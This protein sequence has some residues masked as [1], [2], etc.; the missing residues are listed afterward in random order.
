MFEGASAWELKQL[1][2]DATP[3]VTEEPAKAEAKTLPAEPSKEDMA[4]SP[5]HWPC[6]WSI[7]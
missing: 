2:L 3:P 4:V 7:D 5:R 1:A 6:L